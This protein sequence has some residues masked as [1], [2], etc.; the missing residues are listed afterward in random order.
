M[1][2]YEKTMYERDLPGIRKSLESIAKSLK[3]IEKRIIISDPGDEVDPI[4]ECQG[5]MP[6]WVKGLKYAVDYVEDQKKTN[7]PL[8][9]D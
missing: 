1:T 9:M 2:G 4:E 6:A 5:S 7:D 8:E 3:A